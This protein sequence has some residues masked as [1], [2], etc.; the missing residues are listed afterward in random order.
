LTVVLGLFSFTDEVTKSGI[1]LV[2][3]RIE[4]KEACYYS[5]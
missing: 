3:N 4:R 5:S 1:M 2:C